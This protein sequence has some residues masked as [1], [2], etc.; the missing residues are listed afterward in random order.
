MV[1]T[2]RDLFVRELRERYHIE[3]ELEEKQSG[4]AEAATDEVTDPL[5]QTKQEAE[6]RLERAQELTAI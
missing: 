1:E 2:G 3:R 6:N 5:E 4:L